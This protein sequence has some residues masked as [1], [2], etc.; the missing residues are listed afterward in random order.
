[1]RS[2]VA[3]RRTSAS[4]HLV[5]L[6]DDLQWADSASLELIGYLATHLT[7]EPVLVLATVRDV[8]AEQRDDLLGALSDIARRRG[9]RRLR[10]R[11]L[12]AESTAALVRQTAQRE[13]APRCSGPST[14]APRATRSS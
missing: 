5:V 1:M 3:V 14:S 4:R 7:D 2:P 8:A 6:L 10:L 13:V 9:S 12:D 11:G